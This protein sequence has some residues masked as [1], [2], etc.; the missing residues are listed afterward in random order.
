M[1]PDVLREVQNYLGIPEGSKPPM[2]VSKP[3]AW[4]IGVLLALLAVGVTMAT[5]VGIKRD[6]DFDATQRQLHEIKNRL[7]ALHRADQGIERKL[8]EH[9]TKIENMKDKQR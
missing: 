2:Y 3:Q 1:E 7:D 5:Y 6:Y 8:V 4:A 9:E